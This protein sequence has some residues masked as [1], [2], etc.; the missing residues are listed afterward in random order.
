MSTQNNR[1][2]SKEKLICFYTITI[3]VMVVFDYIT[4]SCWQIKKKILVDYKPVYLSANRELVKWTSIELLNCL[5]N[6]PYMMCNFVQKKIY[7]YS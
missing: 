7:I 1:T 2:F 5:V 3:I 4:V 6:I